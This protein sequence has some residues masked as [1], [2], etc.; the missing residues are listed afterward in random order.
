MDDA[1]K[2]VL[3]GNTRAV[4]RLLRAIDD[5]WPSVQAELAELFAHTGRA[6]VIGVTGSPGVGKSTLVDRL[7][8][9]LR[10]RGR[11]VGV[12]AVD[13]TSPFNGGAILGDRIRMLRHAADPGVFIRSIATRGVFGGVT[14]STRAS[15][16]VLDAMGKDVIIVETVGVGQDEVDIAKSAH[17]TIVV[18]V[19]GLGDE[20]QAIKAGILEV[21]DI[22]AVNKANADGTDQTVASLEMMLDMDGQR[23]G[24]E[25]KPKILRTEALDDVGIDPLIDAVEEHRLHLEVSGGRLHQQSDRRVGVRLEEM[26][27]SRVLEEF[28]GPLIES[29]AFASSV[30][31]VTARETDPYSACETLLAQLRAR[32]REQR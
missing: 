26:F 21:A 23:H 31:S 15:I 24:A 30:R 29:E 6:H 7:T 11:A 8:Q 20:I 5:D 18:V 1:V 16:D 10:E 3:E 12:L 9:H 17:T 13:P 25:W 32:I 4:A 19:P 28:V 22:F 14:E 2:G 27:R